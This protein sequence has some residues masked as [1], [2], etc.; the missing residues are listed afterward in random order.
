MS[1][2]ATAPQSLT[3]PAQWTSAPPWFRLAR[4]IGVAVSP[5]SLFPQ[6]LCC[7][8]DTDERRGLSC[9][10]LLSFVFPLSQ[11]QLQS[12]WVK[13]LAAEGKVEVQLL[14]QGP[15]VD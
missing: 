9:W 12:L 4:A 1:P 13:A 10:S 3:A 7:E 6:A 5:S 11:G 14:L 2:V 8:A 15:G